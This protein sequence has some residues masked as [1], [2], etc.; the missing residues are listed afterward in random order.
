MSYPYPYQLLPFETYKE[1][2]DKDWKSLIQ[3][4]RSLQ[5]ECI[6]LE[7]TYAASHPQYD[8]ELDWRLD[9]CIRLAND[10]RHELLD[11]RLALLCKNELS[12]LLRLQ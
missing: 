11:I 6:Y 3:G 5:N 8:Y 9:D 7:S 12:T 10:I 2:F 4:V 1:W